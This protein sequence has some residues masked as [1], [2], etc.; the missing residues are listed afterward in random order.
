MTF[1]PASNYKGV[2][3]GQIGSVT[4]ARLANNCPTCK[5]T[6]VVPVNTYKDIINKIVQEYA[7]DTYP[8]KNYSEKTLLAEDLGLDSLDELELL[9][10]IEEEFEIEISDELLINVANLG[11]IYQI[12]F[13]E[14]TEETE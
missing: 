9:M 4:N 13:T 7:G 5:G 12:V 8:A 6:G 10:Q 1:K 3:T 14:K 11:H 2:Y